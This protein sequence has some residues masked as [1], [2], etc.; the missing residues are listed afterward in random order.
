MAMTTK[1]MLGTV[2]RQDGHYFSV[3][4][5]DAPAHLQLL[6]LTA[7]QMRGAVVGDTVK[8]AYQTTSSWGLWNVVEVLRG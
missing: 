4:C 2:A 5:P 8:L 6:D 1:T 7:S 3:E